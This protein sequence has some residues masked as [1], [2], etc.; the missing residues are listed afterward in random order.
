MPLNKTSLQN[1]LKDLFEGKNGFP[2]SE[3]DAAQKIAT[4]Y[5]QYTAD[6]VAGTTQPLAA[7]LTA[8]ESTLWDALGSAFTAAKASGPAGVAVLGLAIDDAF[9]AF[10]LTEPVAFAIPPTGPPTMIGVVSLAPPGVLAPGLIA[11][12]IAG[13]VSSPSAAEQAQAMATILDTWTRT[14][15]V[16]NTPVTPPGPSAPPVPL[17]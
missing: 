12:L 16:V 6:A 13:V 17:S 2:S 5:R 4:I 14:V 10:W 1:K 8:V 7:S 11:L 9:V 3:A 15:M